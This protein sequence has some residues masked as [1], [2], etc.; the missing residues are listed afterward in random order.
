MK[1]KKNPKVK[2][3]KVEIPEDAFE[4]KNVKARITMWIGM[5]TLMEVKKRAQDKGLP[6]QTYLNQLIRDS[7]YGESQAS[8]E[9]RL[10]SLEATVHDIREKIAV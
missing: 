4:P 6:Y 10:A 7:V 9:T 8:I 5:D 2:Y 1:S 3:G